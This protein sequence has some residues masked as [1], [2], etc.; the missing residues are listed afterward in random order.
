MT[1]RR[2][3]E[4]AEIHSIIYQRL[5]AETAAVLHV[6]AA[7]AVLRPLAVN[8]LLAGSTP[9]GALL[10]VLEDM[11]V[12]GIDIVPLIEA[13]GSTDQKTFDTNERLIRETARRLVE[14]GGRINAAA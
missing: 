1:T 13:M 6:D 10:R 2:P 5:G 3:L 8:R 9:T 4:P 14:L 7:L 12:A 11:A